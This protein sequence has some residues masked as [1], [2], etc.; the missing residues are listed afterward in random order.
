MLGPRKASSDRIDAATRSWFRDGGIQPGDS[1]WWRSPTTS[2]GLLLI[3]IVALVSRLG[4]SFHGIRGSDAYVYAAHAFSLARGYYSPLTL[5]G[6]YYGY[7]YTVIGLTAAAYRIFGL[8]DWSS[9]VFPLSFGLGAIL[10]TFRLGQLLVGSAAALWGAAIFAVLPLSI[11]FSTLL[12]PDSFIPFF[13]GLAVLSL[14]EADRSPRPRVRFAWLCLLGFSFYACVSARIVSVVFLVFFAGY[15]VFAKRTLS[16][17]N[18]ILSLGAPLALEGILFFWWAGDPLYQWHQISSASP[19]LTQVGITHLSYYPKAIMGL[20]L[21]GFAFYSFLFYVMIAGLIYLLI[22]RPQEVVVPLLWFVPLFLFLEF[23]S[24]SPSRYL[25]IIKNYNYLSLIIIPAVI[26]AGCGLEALW[27]WRP[28]LSQGRLLATGLLVLFLATSVYGTY[29]IHQNMEDDA[30][31]YVLVRTAIQGRPDRPIYV[32]HFRWA[33][34]LDYF[35]GFRNLV[36]RQTGGDAALGF[37]RPLANVN[38]PDAL[39]DVYV[40]VHDRY[41]YWSTSGTPLARAAD[42]AFHT[43]EGEV[44]PQFLYSPPTSWSLILDA[45]DHFGRVRLYYIPPP[46]AVTSGAMHAYGWVN[47]GA[48]ADFSCFC[49]SAISALPTTSSGG[50]A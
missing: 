16:I 45:A 39:E 28:D 40:V 26:F 43:E 37:I 48:T 11:V 20:D 31:P 4:L 6:D 22:V 19:F 14:L 7:R 42:G 10:L 32:H 25:P 27:R 24:M 36:L 5:G 41:L 35:L 30:R 17:W 50:I 46:R 44:I 8:S 29:R 49:P 12:G 15:V 3:C 33:L 2:W 18:L 1:A 38:T 13:S 34:F 9:A 21:G 47:G 23:G